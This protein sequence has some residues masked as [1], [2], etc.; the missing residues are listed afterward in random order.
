MQQHPEL[1]F[2]IE[3]HTD[4][5]GDDAS[6]L[7]LSEDRAKTVMNTMVKLGI[8]ADRLTAKGWGESMPMDTN[9]TPEGKANNRRVEF[10]KM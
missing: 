2:S 6:N 7:T 1:N 10:V 9:S 8:S 4:N 5:D 3:G